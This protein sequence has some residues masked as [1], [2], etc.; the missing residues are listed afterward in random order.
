MVFDNCGSCGK[1]VRDKGVLADMRR[2]NAVHMLRAKIAGSARRLSVTVRTRDP[3]VRE[4]LAR[5]N[6]LLARCDAA[7]LGF[8][9]ERER[10]DERRE[11]RAD[12]KARRAEQT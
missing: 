9:T 11:K 7:E 12:A 6:G 4:E 8:W 1:E 5:L 10:R 2:L 3:A